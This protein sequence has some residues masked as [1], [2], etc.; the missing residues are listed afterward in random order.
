M[1]LMAAEIFSQFLW[2]STGFASDGTSLA[3]RSFPVTF[4]PAALTAARAEIES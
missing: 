3:Q 2:Q 1:Q 4:L